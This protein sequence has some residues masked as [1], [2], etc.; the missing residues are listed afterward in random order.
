MFLSKDKDHSSGYGKN[1]GLSGS[2]DSDRCVIQPS[3][4]FHYKDAAVY[5]PPVEQL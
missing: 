1:F 3:I 5:Q 4:N 2:L